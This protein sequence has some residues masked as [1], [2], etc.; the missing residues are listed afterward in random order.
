M[1][2]KRKRGDRRRSIYIIPNLFTTGSLFFGFYSVMCSVQGRYSLAA[3]LI[4]FAAVMDALDGTVA[5]MTNTTSRFGVEYD[6]LCDLLSFGAA[7]AVLVYLWALT[8]QKLRLPLPSPDD[9][10]LGFG[11]IVAF[12]FLAC[13]ALRLARFNVSAG[14]RDPGFFQGLPIP[15]G[16]GIVAA[17][18]LWHYRFPGPPLLPAGSQVLIMT[19]VLAFLMVSNLDFVSLKN[20][21]FTKNNHPFETLAII[22]IFLAFLIIKAKTVLLPL[23]F[24]YL[25]SGPVV[26]VVRRLRRGG[27]K[28]SDAPDAEGDSD[29]EDDSDKGD[30][31]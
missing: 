2:Q 12:I 4:L 18:V 10:S 27:A 8:P 30:G 7:P 5:R 17:A 21:I 20:K 14:S 22:V 25:A 1:S 24:V 11:L 19:I 16:A 26:T 9:R 31:D 15:G 29:G 28:P 13:G 6:S 23:G 3:A